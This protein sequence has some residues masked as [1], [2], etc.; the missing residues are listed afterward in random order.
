MRKCI[1][2][3]EV[4]L[5]KRSI[6]EILMMLE[7]SIFFCSRQLSRSNKGVLRGLHMQRGASAQANLV[8]VL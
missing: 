1:A 3:Q 2:I 5:L 7:D 8:R 4:I 6:K